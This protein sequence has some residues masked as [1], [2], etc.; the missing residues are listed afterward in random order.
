MKHVDVSDENCA[1]MGHTLVL[2]HNYGNQGS[3]GSMI[4]TFKM[5][6][7]RSFVQLPQPIY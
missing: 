6:V 2:Q 4:Y 1:T 5:V 3:F 7:F